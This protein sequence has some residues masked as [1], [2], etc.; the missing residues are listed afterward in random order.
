[1]PDRA[2]VLLGEFQT[3]PDFAY[4]G[5]Q[6]LIYI[7]GPHHEMRGQKE[8]DVQLTKTLEEAGFTVI[9]FTK[10]TKSW[11]SVIKSYPEIFGKGI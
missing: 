1:M 8:L 9:R 3:Q 7:D 4:S 6:A 11:E 10:N 5:S 2:Q